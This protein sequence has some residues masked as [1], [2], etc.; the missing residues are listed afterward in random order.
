MLLFIQETA[1]EAVENADQLDPEQVEKTLS[2][3]ELIQ[4]SGIGGQV[5]IAILFLLLIFAAY[6]YF[7]RFFALDQS[8]KYHSN[9]R[10]RTN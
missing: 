3:I 10:Y 7:E 2:I 9:L 4:N 6:I 5:I 1:Q 8:A